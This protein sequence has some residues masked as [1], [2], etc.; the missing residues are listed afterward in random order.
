MNQESKE[1]KFRRLA[2]AR[3]KK[4][5]YELGRLT[6]MV[7]QPTYT[8]TDVDAEKLLSAIGSTY[9]TFADLYE[10]IAQGQAIKSSKKDLTDIF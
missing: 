10:K 7:T 9:T 6:N 2:N 3:A 5:I 1:E 4:V 8:I